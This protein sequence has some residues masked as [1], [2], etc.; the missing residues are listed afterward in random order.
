MQRTRSVAKAWW[1]AEESELVLKIPRQ[2]PNLIT[3]SNDFAEGLLQLERR[4]AKSEKD[5]CSRLSCLIDIQMEFPD[6]TSACVPDTFPKIVMLSLVRTAKD[7]SMGHHHHAPAHDRIAQAACH[8]CV[9][10][11]Q[12]DRDLRRAQCVY[13]C[14]RKHTKF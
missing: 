12:P 5:I 10:R 14:F 2:I 11:A 8:A 13:Y 6:M 7:R 9:G 3:H 1:I 4:H